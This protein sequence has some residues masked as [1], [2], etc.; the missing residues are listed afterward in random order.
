MDIVD[1]TR[2]TMAD[3]IISHCKGNVLGVEIHLLDVQLCRKNIVKY[4]CQDPRLQLDCKNVLRLRL[5]IVDATR[6]T[7]HIARAMCSVLK[8]ICLLFNYVEK[9]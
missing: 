1:A 8:F 7:F 5:D 6:L 4:F 2:L 3:I 9:I